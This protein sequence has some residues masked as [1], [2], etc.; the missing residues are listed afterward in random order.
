MIL[1]NKSDLYEGANL[2][3]SELEKIPNFK[4]SCETQEGLNEVLEHLK[5]KFDIE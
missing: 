3:E 2:I 1:Y 4:V 5:K